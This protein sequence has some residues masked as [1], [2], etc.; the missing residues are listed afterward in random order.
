MRTIMVLTTLALGI[1][2]EPTLAADRDCFQ[3]GNP[4]LRIK[5]CSDL[6]DRNPKDAVAYHN[7]AEAHSMVGD[8]DRAIADYSKAIEIKPD[9]ATAFDGRARA[10]AAQGDYVKA[11]P[12]ATRARELLAVAV[13]RPTVAVAK[14]AKRKAAAAPPKT[15]KASAAPAVSD[16]TPANNPVHD[17][18][19]WARF[20][21]SESN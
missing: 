21:E 20:K 8:L 3:Q 1:S 4:Q 19:R 14:S 18:P 10:Y 2:A 17:W 11:V 15:S 12:D 5:G 6:I 16:P 13:A 9:T 7:R